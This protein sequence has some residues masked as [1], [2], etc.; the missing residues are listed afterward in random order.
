MKYFPLCFVTLLAFA[1]CQKQEA[2]PGAAANPETPAAQAAVLADPIHSVVR[3]N[4]TQQGWNPAQPWE[5]ASP[6]NRRALAAIVGPQRV[7]TTS[8]MV[9]DSTYLE[10][11]SPDGTRLL[12]AKVLAVDYEANLALLG[13]QADD[14]N[15]K[16]FFDGTSPLAVAGPPSIG[17]IFELLQVEENGSSLTTQGTLRQVTVSSTFLPGQFFLTFVVKASMQSASSS[18]SLPTLRNGKLVGI[19]ASYDSKEQTCQVIST[20]I[21]TRFLGAAAKGSYQGFPSLGL[22][23]ATT[24]DA[25]FRR[26]L[27]LPENDG[28]LYVSLVRK[29]GSAEAAGVKPG[30]VLTGIGDHI[31]DRRGYYHHERY[32]NLYWSNLVRG[33]RL[34]G[35]SVKLHLLRDGKPLDLDAKLAREETSARLVPSYTFDSAPSYLVKGG[36]VFQELTQPLL[37]SFGENWESQAPLNLLDAARNQD[38]HKGN[39]RRVVFLTGGIPTPAT[40]GY[41]RL[42]NLIVSKVNG[43]EILDMKSMVEAFQHPDKGLHRVEFEDETISIYLDDAVTSHVDQMLQQR[44]ISPLYRAQ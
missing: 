23:T 35:E 15:A 36:L 30:D 22:A 37:E 33:E 26:W 12:P 4:A 24:E 27:K 41:E 42:R 3:I 40:V 34:A 5:K 6:S 32:G 20:D 31:V 25:P 1:S 29:G 17:D 11:E 39:A 44:G 9:A 13:P 38:K 21:I 16:S 10:L 8:E 7:L 28:G 19:L 14:K 18:F 43:R 2:A